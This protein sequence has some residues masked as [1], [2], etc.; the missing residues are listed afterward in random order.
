MTVTINGGGTGS[1]GVNQISI[2]AGGTTRR[3]IDANSL[4]GAPSLVAAR[5]RCG[6]P[7]TLIVDE[8]A[9]SDRQHRTTSRLPSTD[10]STH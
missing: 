8:S 4:L 3:E 9:R 2:T 5:S 10:S 1:G 7:I 6:G